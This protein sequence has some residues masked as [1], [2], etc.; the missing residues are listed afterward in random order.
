VPQIANLELLDE[1]VY[2]ET[3]VMIYRNT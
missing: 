1:R 3:R 2:G